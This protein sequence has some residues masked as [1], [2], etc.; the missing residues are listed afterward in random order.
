MCADWLKNYYAEDNYLDYDKAMVG[1]YGI[2]QINTLIQQAAALRMPC[3]V[4]S[5]RTGRTVFYTSE[6]PPC[7]RQSD[8]G[9]N[10]IGSS[11]WKSKPL[12]R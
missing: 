11:K 1:G 7:L 12:L 9:G 10:Y 6:Y 3:I 4:P 5:T 8:G 2:P